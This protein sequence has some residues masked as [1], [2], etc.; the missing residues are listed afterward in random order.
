MGQIASA[1]TVYSVAYLTER[2]RQLLFNK[3][4]NRFDNNGNDLFQ[5]I[6]FALSDPDMNYKTASRLE[7]GEIPD[8]TGSYEGCIKSAADVKQKYLISVD[9]EMEIVSSSDEYTYEYQTNYSPENELLINVNITEQSGILPTSNTVF[10]P[11][12]GTTGPAT[13]G[14]GVIT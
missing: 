1:T 10:A 3:D 12:G 6:K 9:G 13:G 5:I 7:S 8:L 11:G 14:G 2:G 4:G